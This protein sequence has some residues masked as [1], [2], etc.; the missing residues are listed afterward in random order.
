[1]Y[2]LTG[3]HVRVTAGSNGTSSRSALGYR[4]KYHELSRNVSDTSV[5]RR[6]TPPHVGQ[7]TRYHSSWR[8]SGETPESSGLKS[9]MNGS[10]TGRSSSGTGTAPQDSQ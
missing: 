10:T 1:M 7:G 8:A 6:P 3:S 5:S 4:M 9:A 2:E